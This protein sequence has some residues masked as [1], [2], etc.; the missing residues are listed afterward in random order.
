MDNAIMS[1]R[2]QDPLTHEAVSA[3]AKDQMPAYNVG[4]QSTDYFD[5]S[6]P[7]ELDEHRIGQKPSG[8]YDVP[9][10]HNT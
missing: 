2:S 4:Q 3:Y 8:N 10:S 7:P 5:A 6:L 1:L 9:L